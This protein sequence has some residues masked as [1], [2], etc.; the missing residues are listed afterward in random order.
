MR[1]FTEDHEWVDVDGDIP[2]MRVVN[3]AK[4]NGMQAKFDAIAA[5]TGQ[6][7]KEQGDFLGSHTILQTLELFNSDSLVARDVAEYFSFVPFGEQYEF[8][9]PDLLAAWYTRNIRIYHNI[10]ALADS[11]S[12]RILVIYGA[13]HLGWLRED[14]ANDAS[15]RLRK[16]GEFVRGP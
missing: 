10:R 9:G 16:F 13:G 6:R 1:Y 14:V 11:P 8:A 12:D 4:A 15:V 3:Y 2:Y 7:V 5:R